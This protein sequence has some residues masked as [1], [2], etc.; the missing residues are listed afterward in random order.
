MKS[1]REIF[2]NN[3]DLLE[4]SEVQQLVEYCEELQDE[5]VELKF[6][7]T[8]NKELALIDMIKE[9]IKGCEALDKEQ[10][11]HERFGYDAPDYK[12]TIAYLQRYIHSRCREEKIWIG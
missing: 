5:I 3:R 4:E 1:I 12:S 6:Q 10:M 8:E 9:V 7:K 11:E 2:R